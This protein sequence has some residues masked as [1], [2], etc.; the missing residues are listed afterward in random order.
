MLVVNKGGPRVRPL[1]TAENIGAVLVN[2][3][4]T[5]RTSTRH[6]SQELNIS[7]TMMRILHK[8]LR[9]FAYKIPM[10]Q[11]LKANDHPLHYRFSVRALEQLE[12]DG[13]F[14]QKII[15][16]DEAHL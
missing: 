10:S 5:P 6:R 12:N 11:K 1:R 4:A 8:D 13:D 9:L 7:Q 3:Q 2:V 14:A 15:F 16:L